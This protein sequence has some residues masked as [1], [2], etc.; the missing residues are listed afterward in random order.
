MAIA[1]SE[2]TD[3]LIRFGNSF[4]LS[5]AH[6]LYSPPTKRKKEYKTITHDINGVLSLSFLQQKNARAPFFLFHKRE[7]EVGL[8]KRILK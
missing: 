4:S 6:S 1:M 2:S 5:L 3:T 8:D 7:R